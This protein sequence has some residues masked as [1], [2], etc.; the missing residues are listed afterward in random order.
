MSISKEMKDILNHIAEM[1]EG[2]TSKSVMILLS[3]HKEGLPKE[4]ASNY[5][6]RLESWI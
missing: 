6:G 3:L 1:S 4:E 2:N 5:L